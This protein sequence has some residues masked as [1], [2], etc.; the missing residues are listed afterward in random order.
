M[1][2]LHPPG[3]TLLPDGRAQFL[4]WAPRTKTIALRVHTDTYPDPIT[5]TAAEDGYYH[6]TLEGLAAGDRY[7]YLINGDTTRP[8]PASR[9]QPDGVH[10]AS[11]LVDL[12]FDWTDDGFTPPSA[13]N[14]VFYEMH[15]GTFTEE[16]TFDAIIPHLPRL[17][18]LGITTLQLMPIAEFPGARNWGYDGVHLYAAETAYGGLTGLQRLVDAAHEAGLAVFL[19]LVYNHLGPEGNYL[20]DYGPYF[21]DRYKT[22]WGDAVNFDGPHSDHVRRYFIQ[23]A[24][25]WLDACHVDG[26]RLDATHAYM[27]STA[28]TFLEQLADSIHDWGERHD[29]RILVFAESERGDR[30]TVLP[31]AANGIG[32]DGQWLDDL[33][34]AL[35]VALTGEKLGYYQ[36]FAEPHRFTKI[37]REGFAYT[38]E[39]SPNHKR[40]HGTRSDDIPTDRFVICSQNHDQVGNR[41]LGERL[42][43]LT[44]FEGQKLATGVVLTSPYVPLLFMGQEYGETAPFLYFISHTDENLLEAVREGRRREFAAFEW[45]KAGEPPPDP[46]APETMARCRLNHDLR[47]QGQHAALYE[48][49]AFL[50]R[51]RRENP[52]LTSPDRAKLALHY[53]V[54]YG[55]CIERT[56]GHNAFRTLLNLHP[57]DALAVPFPAGATPW[58]KIIES[59]TWG[60]HADA[61]LPDTPSDNTERLTLP[62]RSFAIYA[63]NNGTLYAHD[64]A[65]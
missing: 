14:T 22:P 30:R 23:N 59:A 3:A 41:M 55:V 4:V 63:D 48:L 34:H 42:D 53:D 50:L 37:L 9:A 11:A 61:T 18:E 17:R 60:T 49:Y 2:Y 56:D 24:L 20:R 32:L 46:G 12:T 45:N 33:H 36:D 64:H 43:V 54:P 13:R 65:R 52:L 31:R 44:D 10:G 27:D 19:D 57:T 58:K 5:M 39:Y 40:R 29:K 28:Y 51:L 62:P 16:G 26:F 8:D 7:E 47:E 38:G 1:T 35:H 21:T 6:C 25:F 15:V